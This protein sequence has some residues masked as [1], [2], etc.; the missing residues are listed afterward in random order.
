M[1]LVFLKQA[2][3]LLVFFN[4]VDHAAVGLQR[5]LDGDGARARA[6]VPADGVAR[7]LQFGQADASHLALGH[8]DEPPLLLPA[9]KRLVRQS[10]RHDC[11]GVCIFNER[12]AELVEAPRS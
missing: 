8:R 12:H 11:V 4:G 3:R 9:Q 1:R 6:D 2:Q 5:H 10:V 7:E